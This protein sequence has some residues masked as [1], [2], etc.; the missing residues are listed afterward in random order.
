MGDGAERQRSNIALVHDYL[1]VMRGAERS[2]AAMADCYP[3]SPIYTLLFDAAEIAPYFDDR[4]VTTSY[5]QRLRVRQKGFRR[6]LPFFPRA[7]E[8]LPVQ[9]YPV[10]LS[11]SS[12]FAHGIR[13]GEGAEH[14]CYCHSPFRYAYFEREQTLADT[15]AAF[16]PVVSRL[17]TRIR[18]W[19]L[20]AS[21][22]VDHYIANSEVTRER[23][24]DYYGRDSAV[25][26]PPVNVDRFEA[27]KPD[28]FFLVVCA[29][30]PHKRIDLALGAARRAGKHVKVV[31]TGPS[32]ARLEAEYPDVAEFLGR[33]SDTELDRLYSRAQALIVPNVEEF[34]IA[35]VEAQAAGRPVLAVDAGGAR[36]IVISG[37]T[38][39]LVPI[40]DAD[41]LAESLRE[42]D[43]EAFDSDRLVSS[44]A[45]FS[46]AGFCDRLTDEV[47]R[48]THPPALS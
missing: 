2:F 20:T 25:I 30:V 35:M 1:L 47:E 24:A 14:V 27:A 15:P 10:V 21:K 28:D 13:P 6:L 23:I 42:I 12:A 4:Q 46:A 32:R 31:G 18:E 9:D 8:R 41:A 45:R 39:Q 38:G 29:L 7:V 17:L 22:R 33:V 3:D 44:A 16:R 19:D 26:H 37:E 48:L 43:F 5:L 11:S 34:G 40:G 36:E